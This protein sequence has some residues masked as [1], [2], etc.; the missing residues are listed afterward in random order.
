MLGAIWSCNVSGGRGS[1]R[2]VLN[3]K[4]AAT[5]LG[6]SLALPSLITALGRIFPYLPRGGSIY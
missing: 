4:L 2:A 5:R 3:H 1:R 6:G